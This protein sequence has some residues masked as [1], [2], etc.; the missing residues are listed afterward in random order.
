MA[1]QVTRVQSLL[2]QMHSGNAKVDMAGALLRF[3]RCCRSSVLAGAIIFKSIMIPFRQDLVLFLSFVL[4]SCIY[5]LNLLPEGDYSC[6]PLP[7][8]RYAC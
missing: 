3:P 6:F 4:A 1:F 5:R 7:L 2:L 8:C